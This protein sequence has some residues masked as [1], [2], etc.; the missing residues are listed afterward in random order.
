MTKKVRDIGEILTD[1][2]PKLF[3]L[4]LY[5]FNDVLKEF[6]EATTRSTLLIIYDDKGKKLAFWAGFEGDRPVVRKVDPKN[7]PFAT[8]EVSMH[9][10]TFIKIIK[11][12]R[13]FRAAYLYNLI[14]IKSNDG[15]PETYH[16]L[17]WSAY[18][19]KLVEILK[20]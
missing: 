13:D 10:D 6:P 4:G 16:L 20:K 7:P 2:L 5:K 8:T 9:V 18:F 1:L 17:L 15:L 19:D 3:K 14:D 11:G 12:E